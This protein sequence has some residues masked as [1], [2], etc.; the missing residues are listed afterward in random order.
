[1]RRW[2]SAF[3]THQTAPKAKRCIGLSA[4]RLTKTNGIACAA[5]KQLA[6]A[7]ADEEGGRGVSSR[8]DKRFKAARVTPGLFLFYP[9]AHAP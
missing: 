8:E 4:E 1:M 2:L 3:I 7:S 6:V 5:R 9:V